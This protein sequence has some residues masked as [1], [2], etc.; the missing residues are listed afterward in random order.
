MM[1]MVIAVFYMHTYVCKYIVL[2]ITHYYIRDSN[3]LKPIQNM[4][5]MQGMLTA[6][7]LVCPGM[8]SIIGMG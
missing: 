1:C 6:W 5:H 7:S 3:I 4:L 8:H 2:E